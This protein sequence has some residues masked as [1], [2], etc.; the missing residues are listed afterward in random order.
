MNDGM[1]FEVALTNLKAGHRVS[2]RGWNGREMWLHL[3][4]PDLGS[5]MTLPYIYLRTAQGEYVPWAPS[6]ADLFAEDWFVRD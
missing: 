1:S 6:Q 5:K 4:R 2:R 3:Q